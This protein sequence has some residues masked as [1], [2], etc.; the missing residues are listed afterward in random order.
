MFNVMIHSS[1]Q[2]GLFLFFFFFNSLLTV[3]G[4]TSEEAKSTQTGESAEKN[5]NVV[6][7]LL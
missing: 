6:M 7:R 1:G 5:G 4:V 2:I 3:T